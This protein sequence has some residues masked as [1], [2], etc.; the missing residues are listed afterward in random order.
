M[1]EMTWNVNQPGRWRRPSVVPLLQEKDTD[2]KR[3]LLNRSYE[4][5]S[6]RGS[7]LE[8]RSSG[9]YLGSG[10]FDQYWLVHQID[11]WTVHWRSRACRI[12][13][14]VANGGIYLM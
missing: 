2:W 8:F 10:M 12:R 14:V 4:P 3:Y 1:V 13:S 5:L 11:G 9:P 6:M 7:Y